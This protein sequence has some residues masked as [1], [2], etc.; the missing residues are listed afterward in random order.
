MAYMGGAERNITKAERN[1]TKAERNITQSGTQH[2]SK[3]NATT[4]RAERN[5]EQKSPR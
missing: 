4:P 5:N 3:R 1:I 2:H